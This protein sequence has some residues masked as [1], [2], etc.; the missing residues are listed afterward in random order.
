[1]LMYDGFHKIEEFT[2]NMKGIP[3]KR[4]RILIK[5]AVAAVATDIKRRVALVYQYRP[6]TGEKLYELPAGL[7][8]KEGLS[9][10]EILIEELY[11]ECGI[12]K[13]MIEAISSTPVHHYYMICGS[14]DAT[15]SLFRVRL[16]TIG[17]TKEVPDEDVEKVEWF[18]IDQL[19]ELIKEGTVKDAKTI[20][21]YY[22]LLHENKLR[23]GGISNE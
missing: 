7:L 3:K 20:M 8:D 13:S 4:E 14:S 22:I 15:M 17:I 18:S 5:S 21:A 12:E 2:V 11:E 9:P 10:Q 6:C 16:N 23:C 19:S 1:M